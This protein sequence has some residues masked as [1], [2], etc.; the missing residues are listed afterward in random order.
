M[1]SRDMVGNLSSKITLFLLKVISRTKVSEMKI[2][3]EEANEERSFGT[4]ERNTRCA[5]KELSF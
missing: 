1:Q 2:Y 3:G 5:A 4:R